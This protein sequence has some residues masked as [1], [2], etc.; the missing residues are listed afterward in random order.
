M[1]TP[2]PIFSKD[3]LLQLDDGGAVST[4]THIV[5]GFD[6]MKILYF[7]VVSVLVIGSK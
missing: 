6:D 4:D 2:S 1:S 5:F 7:L 3:R